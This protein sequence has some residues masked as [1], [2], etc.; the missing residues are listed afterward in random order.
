MALH[1]ARWLICICVRKQVRC[2]LLY[3]LCIFLYLYYKEKSA[4]TFDHSWRKK[5]VKKRECA[6]VHLFPKMDVEIAAL[7]WAQTRKP[8]WFRTFWLIEHWWNG[9]WAEVLRVIG[10]EVIWCSQKTPAVAQTQPIRS[11]M[12]MRPLWLYDANSHMLM[13][14]TYNALIYTLSVNWLGVQ[15]HFQFVQRS[16]CM[17]SLYVLYLS[18][19]WIY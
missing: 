5:S 15:S 6:G 12:E 11:L 9:M 16:D 1:C 18:L 4:I 17:W 19:I 2:S 8:P 7:M 3:S 14:R 13:A 10:S